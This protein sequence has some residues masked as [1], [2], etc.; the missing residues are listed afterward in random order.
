MILGQVYE[1][2]VILPPIYLNCGPRAFCCGLFP[3]ILFILIDIFIYLD[4]IF[5]EFR[6]RPLFPLAR[7]PSVERYFREMPVYDFPL[8]YILYITTFKLC[9]IFVYSLK[10][11]VNNTKRAIRLDFHSKGLGLGNLFNASLYW[12]RYHGFFTV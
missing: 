8:Q 1:I 6:E 5:P 2:L 3:Q 10:K 4:D 12:E 7:A 9:K 11:Q